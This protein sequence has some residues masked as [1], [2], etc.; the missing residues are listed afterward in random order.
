MLYFKALFDGLDA[1][2]GGRPRG[3]CR[4]ST[5]APRAG[6]PALHAELARRRPGDRGAPGAERQPAHPARARGPCASAAGRSRPGTRAP[7]AALATPPLIALE[8]DDRAWLHARIGERF[9]A[10][11]GRRL[12]R[13]GARACARAATCT[14]TCRRCAPSA[15]GRRGRRSTAATS[16][17]S[18]RRAIAATRQ[19]AKRQ[20]TW[21][22]SMPWRAGRRLRR[23][24]TRSTRSSASPVAT[25]EEGRLGMSPCSTI[26]G[27]AKRYGDEH[28]LRRRRPRPRRRR[29]RRGR[30]RVGR[31]QVDAAQL[32][33]RPRHASTP[34]GCASPAPTS[35]RSA[36][37]R[38]RCSGGITSA[39]CSRRSTSCRT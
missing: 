17:R 20:L 33:R 23:A 14:P 28:R 15:I 6:W 2:A 3:A 34:A 19:L 37:R 12:R 16:A 18:R 38:R 26:A 30:R 4:R 31:R 11:L 5:R 32:R 27:L 21:L 8:P 36:N 1:L 29:V 9:A 25:L 13:R 7:D 39:S 24:P 35:T 10:M 22:R